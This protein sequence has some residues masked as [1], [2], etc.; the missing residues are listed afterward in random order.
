MRKVTEKTFLNTAAS[1]FL[2]M[3][4]VL[5]FKIVFIASLL[6]FSCKPEEKKNQL[7]FTDMFAHMADNIIVPRYNDLYLSLVDLESSLEEVDFENQLSFLTVQNQFKTAYISWQSVSVFEFGPA[8]EYSSLLRSNCNSFPCNTQKVQENIMSGSYDLS[9]V[10]NYEAKGFPALD[11]LLFYNEYIS[12]A[13]LAYAKECVVDMKQRVESVIDGWDNYRNIFVNENGVGGTSSLSLF[14]NQFLYD[15][16]FLKRNKFGLP[17]G[18]ATQFF[19]PI[20]Q[21]ATMVEGFY[22]GMSFSLIEA[23]LISLRD[24]FLGVVD[25]DDGVSLYDKLQEGGATS[26]VED[27]GLAE[28]MAH[29]F[30]LCQAHIIQFENTLEEEI[31]SQNPQ[32]SE[33]YGVFQKMVPMIKNDMRSYL[34]VSV[35]ISDSDGD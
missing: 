7:D 34:S 17:S 16:E 25:G 22:S 30:G 11:Y 26:T 13:E 6:L 27:G 2:Y 31:L 9:S 1:N 24:L 5:K 32:L 21:D 3:I 29:Q 33:A 12:Q 15:Y 19:I 28:L 35:T 18:F 10:S 14:F 8:A 23:N 20:P 4:R